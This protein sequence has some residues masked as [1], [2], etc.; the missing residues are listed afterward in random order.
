MSFPIEMNTQAL[1]TTDKILNLTLGYVIT[2][3]SSSEPD[4]GSANCRRTVV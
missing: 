4:S 1:A 3:R 2:C